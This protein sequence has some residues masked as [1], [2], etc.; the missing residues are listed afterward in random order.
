MTHPA[1]KFLQGGTSIGWSQW[2]FPLVVHHSCERKSFLIWATGITKP[3]EFEYWFFM[4][5]DTAYS[6]R[7]FGR[8]YCYHLQS[9]KV[10]KVRSACG[11]LAWL[12]L[13]LWIWK[14]YI[15]SEIPVNCV[16]L[17]KIIH[18][19]VTIG[20]TWKSTLMLLFPVFCTILT[21]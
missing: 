7:S 10:S 15:F 9:R 17:Q 1:V 13:R 16:R 6:G 5:C 11:L 21:E 2:T 20:R 3:N 8:T 19:K 12:T 18:F 14:Q 4:R